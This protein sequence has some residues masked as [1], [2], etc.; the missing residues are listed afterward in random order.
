MKDI[1]IEQI[2]GCVQKSVSSETFFDSMSKSIY[3]RPIN[4]DKTLVTT[5]YQD[6][7][8]ICDKN[9]YPDSI[10]KLRIAEELTHQIQV[11]YQ[12]AMEKFDTNTW[13][14]FTRESGVFSL[15]TPTRRYDFPR[16]L[17]D[18]DIASIY[19][20]YCADGDGAPGQ[21]V[22]KKSQKA[23]DNVFLDREITA[24]RLL[25]TSATPYN[26]HIPY[27]LDTVDLSG[28]Y[29]STILRYFDGYDLPTIRSKFPNGLEQKHVVWIMLRVL[30]CL[31][32][33][34]NKGIIHGNIQPAH[35]MVRPHDHNVLLVDWCYSMVLSSEREN[36]FS[37]VS[38]IYSPP[39][40][41]NQGN[42]SP[43]T[44]IYS[45]GKTMMYLLG[46]D[47][48]H[49]T[50]P[51]QVDDRLKRF[52]LFCVYPSSLGRPQDAWELHEQLQNLRKYLFGEHK[53]EIFSM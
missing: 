19:A 37:V 50:F 17:V 44:D 38:E 1:T 25:H 41:Q 27:L 30:R 22:L 52:L 14:V 2:Y 11:F 46:G 12:R 15:K 49:N 3:L 36:K 16:H 24:L 29:R 13:Q 18:G 9:L 20:G 39:E 4:N 51:T 32:F 5:L 28:Q 42:P 7:L 47:P 21:V 53:F 10:D 34:H 8:A 43:A 40:A 33:V 31:G 45:L 35:I 26:K 48:E 23:E 6:V